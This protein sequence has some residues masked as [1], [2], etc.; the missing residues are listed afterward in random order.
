M[1]I[2]KVGDIKCS[3]GLRKDC[4]SCESCILQRKLSFLE[5]FLSR[6]SEAKKQAFIQ[7]L[8]RS[9]SSIQMISS[10]VRLLEPLMHKDFVYAK[11]KANATFDKDL[12]IMTNLSNKSVDIAA[13]DSFML[14]E[15]NWFASSS[16]WAKF[17]YLLKVLKS[18]NSYTLENVTTILKKQYEVLRKHVLSKSHRGLYQEENSGN[19][20]IK[21]IDDEGRVVFTIISF[22]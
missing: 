2:R 19:I 18:C 5:E 14:E 13:V 6:I 16:S 4:G 20:E 17:N 12:V 8:L 22:M 21:T 10:L 15:R 11:S 7:S 3:A 9:C 1:D